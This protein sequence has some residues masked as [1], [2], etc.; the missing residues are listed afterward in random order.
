[1]YQRQKRLGHID[2]NHKLTKYRFIVHCCVD[3]YSR[4][5]VYATLSDTNRADTVLELFIKGVQE[6]ALPL[7]VSSD[8]GLESVGVA[9]YM[10]ENRGLDRGS[11]I[12]G[13]PASSFGNVNMTLLNSVIIRVCMETQTIVQNSLNKG[14]RNNK[15][16]LPF[17]VVC[18]TC[19]CMAF[20]DVSERF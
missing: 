18:I 13:R 10:L 12:T 2:G 17:H 9:Q 19:D 16:D 8:Q 20:G 14:G 4:I 1:M 7:R 3:E 5:I 15:L 11:L 6:F